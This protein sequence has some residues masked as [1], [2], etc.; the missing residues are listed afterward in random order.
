MNKQTK[1][2][3]SLWFLSIIAIVVIAYNTVELREPFVDEQLPTYEEITGSPVPTDEPIMPTPV[4]EP[5]EEYVETVEV[6]IEELPEPESLKGPV[7]CYIEEGGGQVCENTYVKYFDPENIVLGSDDFAYYTLGSDMVLWWGVTVNKVYNDHPGEFPYLEEAARQEGLTVVQV[8]LGKIYAE[9]GGDRK[10]KIEGGVFNDKPNDNTYGVIQMNPRTCLIVPEFFHLD[11]SKARLIYWDQEFNIYIGML[12]INRIIGTVSEDYTNKFYSPGDHAPKLFWALSFYNCGRNSVAIGKCYYFGGPQYARNILEEFIP[13]IMYRYNDF[14][15]EYPE[16]TFTWYDKT[17]GF[18][19]PETTL[20]ARSLQVDT[21]IFI[22]GWNVPDCENG[23]Y[24]S[25]KIF[26]YVYDWAQLRNMDVVWVETGSTN[27]LKLP[28]V[29]EVLSEIQ[30]AKGRVYIVGHSAGADVA[31]AAAY[32]H[33]TSYD[34]NKINGVGIFDSYL[35][36]DGLNI[37]S[38]IGEVWSQIPVWGGS[39]GSSS[40]SFGSIDFEL[41][42]D[43]YHQGIAVSKDAQYSLIDFFNN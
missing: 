34:Y 36:I 33:L 15:E 31:I 20:T 27:D 14:L 40:V 1:I 25:Q 4:M 28:Y 38:W 7:E 13:M 29:N 22:C 43:E 8:M 12:D 26:G 35:W 32:T 19:K 2:F 37:G 3:I 30:K 23:K 42:E 39:S 10:V 5:T 16:R 17:G 18:T 9:S 41:F 11:C 6:T 21:I 24:S